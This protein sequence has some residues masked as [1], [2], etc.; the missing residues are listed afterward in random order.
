MTVQ[1]AG[2]PLQFLSQISFSHLGHDPSHS[3]SLNPTLWK[4]IILLV[5]YSFESETLILEQFFGCHFPIS[6][7]NCEL[8]FI[9]KNV[10]DF[11][12]ADTSTMFAIDA[13]YIITWHSVISSLLIIKYV[14][15]RYNTLK[16]NN[17]ESVFMK[18]Y[19]DLQEKCLLLIYDR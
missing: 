1:S 11:L 3:P 10:F 14:S 6:W 4:I 12:F 16:G 17:H 18:F 8:L 7:L 15:L 9:W 19:S 13:V 5:G 2:T